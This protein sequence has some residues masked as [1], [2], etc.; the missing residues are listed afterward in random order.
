MTRCA[1]ASPR[2]RVLLTHGTATGWAEGAALL[3]RATA[4][5][6]LPWDTPR[7]VRR[8]LR[9]FRPAPAC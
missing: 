3:R 7:A 6:W 2:L 4:Q 8:F 5:A 9:H 1:S